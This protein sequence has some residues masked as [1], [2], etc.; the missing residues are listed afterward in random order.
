MA[1]NK[2]DASPKVQ[3][4]VSRSHAKPIVKLP[5]AVKLL[6]ASISN[7]DDRAAFKNS[8]LDAIYA[9]EVHMK[10]SGKKK[11]S[12]EAAVTI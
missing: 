2:K 8:M 1:T 3:R 10:T 9:A 5:K 11:D 7:K 4:G 12:A 6:M